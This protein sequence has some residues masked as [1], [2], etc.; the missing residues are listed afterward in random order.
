MSYLEDSF[1]V[2]KIYTIA[3]RVVIARR[4][5]PELRSMTTRADNEEIQ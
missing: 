5:C 3:P 1:I 4:G 2:L